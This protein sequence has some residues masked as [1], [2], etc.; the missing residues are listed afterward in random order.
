MK[1][2]TV[3]SNHVKYTVKVI[4]QKYNGNNNAKVTMQKY[5]VKTNIVEIQ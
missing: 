1:K 5:T 3:N 2:Y 4:M